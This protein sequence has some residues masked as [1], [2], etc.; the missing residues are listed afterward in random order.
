[1]E[2]TL[3]EWR[4]KDFDWIISLS[5]LRDEDN[6]Y[7]NDQDAE[8]GPDDTVD[9]CETRLGGLFDGSR[10]GTFR[11]SIGL[12]APGFVPL[13]GDG[14][15]RKVDESAT[16]TIYLNGST[17]LKDFPVGINRAFH[18]LGLSNSFIG[19][20]TNS[21]AMKALIASGRIFSNTVG[22]YYGWDGTI[23][24]TSI[25]GSLVLGGYDRAKVDGARY[26]INPAYSIN[27]APGCL[28]G[29]QL[30]IDDI[31][32]DFSNGTSGSILENMRA[33]KR[34]CINTY[35][36]GIGITPKLWDKFQ[37]LTRSEESGRIEDGFNN[38]GFSVSAEGA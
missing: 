37:A 13:E 36:E 18:L 24:S 3:Y 2:V 38:R 19:L 32:V 21:T 1:M 27:P 34:G 31:T 7:I 22:M 20:N 11:S 15:P 5:V 12:S 14:N 23:P 6:T 25:D 33:T 17:A 8:C 29:L 35:Q 9:Q 10:S 28:N 4:R 26:G 16:D 30:R